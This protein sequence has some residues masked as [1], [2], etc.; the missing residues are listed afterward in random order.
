MSVWAFSDIHGNRKLFDAIKNFIKEDDIVYFLGDA[1]D[2]GPDGWEIIK[3]ILADE[4]FIY[5]KGNH[6]DMLVKAYFEQMEGDYSSNREMDLWFWNGGQPNSNVMGCDKVKEVI[7]TVNKLALLPL[8]AEYINKNGE[9]IHM[10]HAGWS[11]GLE[12]P[13]PEEWIWDRTHFLDTRWFG[14]DN[15]I[16][17]HGHT[18]IPH[19]V[20]ELSVFYEG[21]AE[22]ELEPG[23]L[24]Y[25]GGHKICIDCGA[26]FTGVTTLINLDTFDEEVF[27]IE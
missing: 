1:C 2:R 20:E 11:M 22:E 27:E 9:L 13:T 21:L 14:P 23:A 7:N 3:E 4:R 16:V 6:E 5:L 10:S 26:H 18:P 19:L 17:I 8:T 24:W 15:A 12:T 25:C